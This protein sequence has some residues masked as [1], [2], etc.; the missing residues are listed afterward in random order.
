M[1]LAIEETGPLLNPL[2]EID[3]SLLRISIGETGTGIWRISRLL[4]RRLW[5]PL[6]GASGLP[7]GSPVAICTPLE[8]LRPPD[9]LFW[10]DG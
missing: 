5:L 1:I 10:M 8:G 3:S 2:I 7:G 6:L 4:V 9:A